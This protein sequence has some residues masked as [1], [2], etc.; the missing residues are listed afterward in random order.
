MPATQVLPVLQQCG[1][2]GV[3]GAVVISAGFKETDDAGRARHTTGVIGAL[4]LTPPGTDILPHEHTTPKAKSDRL[5]LLRASRAN[6]SAIWGL[7]LAKGLTDL[8]PVDQPPTADF[9][10][11]AG[12]E[13]ARQLAAMKPA[14]GK[15]VVIPVANRLAAETNVRTPYFMADLNRSFPGRSDGTD[16]ERL[17]A[18]IMDVVA[19]F[20]PA[21][22]M[23]LHEA[24]SASDAEW[25]NR[26]ERHVALFDS[27]RAPPGAARSAT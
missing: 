16:T 15:M 21:M 12:V 10:D 23:D 17:A 27:G 18:A 25:R 4:E 3:R 14:R 20:R 13:A 6:L 19:R 8:L 2:R 26:L 7:S 1:A 5:D 11:E 9:T 24:G 22:A